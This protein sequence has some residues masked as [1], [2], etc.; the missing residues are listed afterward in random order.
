MLGHVL[1]PREN[2]VREV[3][4]RSFGMLAF[5]VLLTLITL[6]LALLAWQLFKPLIGIPELRTPTDPP[7]LTP[8]A[9]AGSL[10]IVL[11]VLLFFF[12]S[13]AVVIAGVVTGRPGRFPLVPWWLVAV[14]AAGFLAVA[15]L[16][17]V[18]GIQEG[19]ARMLR[20]SGQTV[21]LALMFGWAV[22]PLRRSQLRARSFSP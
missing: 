5:A 4:P 8:G 2:L 6:L 18:L 13:A 22:L 21:V 3:K 17:L 11:A 14:F 16:M 20:R 15:L 19:N 7:P 9:R 12:R 1:D 10:A